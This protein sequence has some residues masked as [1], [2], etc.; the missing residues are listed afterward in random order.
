[1]ISVLIVEDNLMIADLLADLLDG[2]GYAVSG[3]AR[4]VAE[5]VSLCQAHRPDYA[6]VDLHLADD[7]LGTELIGKLAEPTRMGVLFASDNASGLSLTSAQ[8]LAFIAK[9]FRAEDLVDA[10]AVVV[11]IHTKGSSS[12]PHPP[13]F[14]LLEASPA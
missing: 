11:E 8:G 7:L 12:L 5:A 4:T 3:I 9:P 13:G 1:M 2:T 14:R 6:I 10:L